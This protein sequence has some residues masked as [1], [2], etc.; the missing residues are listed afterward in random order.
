MIADWRPEAAWNRAKLATASPR[1]PLRA[2]GA[3]SA[4]TWIT[5]TRRPS[6]N[7]SGGAC[8]GADAPFGGVIFSTLSCASW[9]EFM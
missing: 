4:T 5:R 3:S 9:G 2:N 8:G 1:P 6:G 7:A